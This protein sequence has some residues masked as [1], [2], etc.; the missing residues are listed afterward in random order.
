[1]SEFFA[2]VVHRMMRL[3]GS[4]I[5]PGNPLTKRALKWKKD[6][7]IISLTLPELEEKVKEKNLRLISEQKVDGQSAIME[8]KNG[9]A[10][11][12]S[13]GGSLIWD[14]PVLDEIEKLLKRK[15]VTQAIM[16]GELAGSEDGKILHFDKSESLI[17]NPRSDK[18]KIHWYPYQI[19][20]LN[21]EEIK[22]DYDSYM[23][24]W[25]KL[26]SLF[27]GADRIHVVESYI[28]GVPEL[29]KSW[30]K[31]VEK[32]KNEGIVVRTSDNKV[33]KSK[34]VFMYDLVVVAVGDK[35]GKN[36]PKHLIGNTLMAF[37]DKDEV[38]RIAGEVGTGWTREES[39][40]LFSWAQKNKVD[41]DNTYV[42]V[43]P[44]KIMEVQY[45]RS[46]IKD[47]PAYKY[48]RGKYE[49]LDKRPSG[50]IVKP[51][52]IR[53]RTDKSVNP[54]DLRLTQIP[55]WKESKSAMIKKVLSMFVRSLLHGDDFSD[56]VE[57]RNEIERIKLEWLKQ[58][59]FTH[60]D[61][62]LADFFNDAVTEAEQK[63]LPSKFAD[64]F[65]EVIKKHI[66]KKTPSATPSYAKTLTDVSDLI[67][68]VNEFMKK[69]K[70]YRLCTNCRW[71]GK[72]WKGE[73]GCLDTSWTGRPPYNPEKPVC[74]GLNYEPVKG[75]S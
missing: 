33:Y 14:I 12:G 43:K 16:V 26:E 71:W 67:S 31:L 55:D 18:S 58:L 63:N 2:S 37:M 54:D 34:P 23:A 39:K 46:S 8:Y 73:M 20:E 4:K 22:D 68:D 6:Q 3:A 53:Y 7:G 50:S 51:R 35:K 44:S 42:W 75:S 30:K 5:Q 21:G 61:K 32:D 36:W 59:R 13:L 25:P 45:E 70:L 17:K 11:F 10:R 9:K 62:D 15:N 69:T 48:S 56:P 41:E 19:L 24:A 27:K 49:K 60:R 74:N 1:M 66:T 52:F 72:D 40:E 38:F 64:D 28:G 57:F 29:K 47:M 65:K